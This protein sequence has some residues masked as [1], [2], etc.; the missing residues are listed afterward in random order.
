M[1]EDYKRLHLQNEHQED[2]I[3][4]LRLALKMVMM[5]MCFVILWLCYE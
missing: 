5:Y 1:K 3:E 2:E 4:R